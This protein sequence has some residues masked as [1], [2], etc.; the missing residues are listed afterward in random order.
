MIRNIIFDLCGPIITLNL[1]M[2]NEKFK[3]FGVTD[4]DKPYRHLYDLGITKRFEQNLISPQDFCDEVR[5][6]FSC[7]SQTSGR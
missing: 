4:I 1:D 2:M 5:E 7:D 6:A 3:S